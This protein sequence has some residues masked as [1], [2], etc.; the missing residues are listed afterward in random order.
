MKFPI[1]VPVVLRVKLTGPKGSR[2]CDM[3]LDTGAMYTAV[4]WDIMKDIG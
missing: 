3:L 1:D 4:S 2:E